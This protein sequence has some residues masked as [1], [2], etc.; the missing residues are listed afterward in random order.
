MLD[1]IETDRGFE[2][3][4]N[5]GVRYLVE[6]DFTGHRYR[7]VV[8]GPLGGSHQRTGYHPVSLDVAQEAAEAHHRKVPAE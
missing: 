6:H 5:K 4:G 1:W 3:Q 2:A 8:Y 7:T